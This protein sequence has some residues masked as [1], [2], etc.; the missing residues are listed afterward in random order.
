MDNDALTIAEAID[1]TRQG[2]CWTTTPLKG[3]MV[4]GLITKPDIGPHNILRVI[5]WAAGHEWWRMPAGDI[6]DEV[7]YGDTRPC[8]LLQCFFY[9][10]FER[11]ERGPLVDLL[12]PY[13]SKIIAAAIRAE[14][15]E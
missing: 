12:V 15:G 1:P 10:W 7:D 13:A 6:F 8:G 5:E 2:W 14:K 11:E 4:Q 3:P 9:D